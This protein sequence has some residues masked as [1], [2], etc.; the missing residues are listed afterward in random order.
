MGAG[1]RRKRL[2]W[3]ETDTTQASALYL[4]R[5]DDEGLIASP[6]TEDAVL[7]SAHEGLINFHPT[8]QP[9]APGPDHG[10]AQFV[11]P[12]PR[13]PVTA[14]TQDPL[15]TQSARSVLLAGDVPD[16]TKPE[17][18]GRMRV[19]EDGARRNRT[20]I[21]ASGTLQQDD[22]LRPKL[23]TLAPRAMEPI[24]PA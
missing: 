2:G 22:P 12:R 13:R 23:A 20:L 6:P 1:W 15:Q 9:V 5:D 19:L 14:Q 21:V 16:R 8:V 11:Q 10:A 18:E 7:F 3:N 4:D 17:R 24:G